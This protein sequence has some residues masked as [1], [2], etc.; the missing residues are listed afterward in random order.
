MH[1]FLT[2]MER[3]TSYLNFQGDFYTYGWPSWT[4]K[5]NIHNGHYLNIACGIVLMQHVLILY[6][7]LW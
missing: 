1:V 2:Y 6:Q 7:E 3:S 5:H 4:L